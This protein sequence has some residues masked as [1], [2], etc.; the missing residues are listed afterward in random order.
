MKMIAIYL[1]IGIVFFEIVLSLLK[2]DFCLAKTAFYSHKTDSR[3]LFSFFSLWKRVISLQKK[4]NLANHRLVFIFDLRILLE[5]RSIF[6]KSMRQNN[7]NSAI[8]CLSPS[9]DLIYYTLIWMLFI[10]ECNNFCQAIVYRL[11][12]GDQKPSMLVLPFWLTSCIN[13]GSIQE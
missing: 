8:T 5:T 11:A 2:F 13:S 7:N 9:I 12:T 3:C 6:P 10:D 1:S 4:P